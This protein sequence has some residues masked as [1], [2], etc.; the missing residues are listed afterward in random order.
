V[1]SERMSREERRTAILDA[2]REVFVAKGFDATRMEDVAR[3]AG[4]AKGLL[5]KHFTSKDALFEALVDRQGQI[6][7]AELR[8]L[9]DTADVATSPFDATRRGLELW[10]RQFSG[11][12]ATFQLTDPGTHG[13]Y[14][15]LRDRMRTVIAEAI[16]AVEPTIDSR[17]EW[18]AAAAVQGAAESVALAWRDRHDDITEQQA[19]DVLT[20]FCFGGLSSLQQQAAAMRTGSAP[21]SA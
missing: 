17:Y 8:R 9:L 21:K 18:L 2:A 19:H 15:R 14:D 4:I 11:D 10:L 3:A 13:A 1:A 5:Y 7:V 16:H 6:Y 12:P 20:L